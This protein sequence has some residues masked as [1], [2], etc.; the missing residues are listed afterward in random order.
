MLPSPAPQQV[1]KAQRQRVDQ[2]C[3]PPV[4]GWASISKRGFD[5]IELPSRP[6][7]HIPVFEFRP[8]TQT[9]QQIV[10]VGIAYRSGANSMRGCRPQ[11]LFDDDDFPHPFA[12][13]AKKRGWLGHRPLEVDVERPPRSVWKPV[14]RRYQL[15][16]AASA[17][18]CTK[19]RT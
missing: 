11:R 19:R 1:Q 2:V 18:F 14:V 12:C 13:D 6:S 4:G 7:D 8:L 3:L 5:L 9:G 10:K 15:T 16:L 17:R